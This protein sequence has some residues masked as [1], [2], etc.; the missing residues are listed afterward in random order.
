MI[1]SWT[2]SQRIS[3]IALIFAISIAL[4]VRLS[5]NRTYISDPQPDFAPR[6]NELT[7]RVNPNEADWQT[8]AVVP[9]LGEKQAKQIVAYREEFHRTRPKR[10][11]FQK[12]EDLLKVTG[13]GVSMM[14]N[15]SPHLVFPASEPVR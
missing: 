15:L 9:G 10:T 6:A 3:L 8:L 1:R 11:P 7:D 14:E 12:P 2:T 13:I 5:S 4:A